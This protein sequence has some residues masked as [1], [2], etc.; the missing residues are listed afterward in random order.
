[1]KNI[2]VPDDCAVIVVSTVTT[3]TGTKVSMDPQRIGKPSEA[4]ESFMGI[5]MGGLEKFFQHIAMAAGKPDD[6][7]VIDKPKTPQ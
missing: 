2:E 1:M 6:F 3:S 7:T 5:M 4:V